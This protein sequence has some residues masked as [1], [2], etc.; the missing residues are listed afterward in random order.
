MTKTLAERAEEARIILE[1]ENK[2]KRE[3]HELEKSKAAIEYFKINLPEAKYAGDGKFEFDGQLFNY[4]QQYSLS[5]LLDAYELTNYKFG[6]FSNLGEYGAYLK[7]KKDWDDIMDKL[8]PK[9][10]L[11]PNRIEV[12]QGA[13]E[14]ISKLFKTLFSRNK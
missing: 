14:P 8:W 3:A 4:T 9:P 13:F 2:I 10:V 6:G 11:P 7:R 5:G 12:E 1:A